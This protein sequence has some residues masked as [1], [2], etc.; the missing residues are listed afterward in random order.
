MTT[1]THQHAVLPEHEAAAVRS[2][3]QARRSASRAFQVPRRNF[4]WML[5]VIPP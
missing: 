1:S 4:T 5:S 2:E 3:A